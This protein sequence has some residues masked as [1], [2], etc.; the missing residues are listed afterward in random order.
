MSD[1][2]MAW[3]ED[4]KNHPM[5]ASLGEA[6]DHYRQTRKAQPKVVLLHPDT[7]KAVQGTL[8]TVGITIRERSD[9][10]RNTFYVGVE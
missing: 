10:Q 9:I 6:L 1:T 3:R 7:A 2:Y 4:E 5:H 8:A